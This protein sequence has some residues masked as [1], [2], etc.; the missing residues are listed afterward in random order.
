MAEA[1]DRVNHGATIDQNSPVFEIELDPL[2]VVNGDVRTCI[3]DTP[4]NQFLFPSGLLKEY[5]FFAG[6]LNGGW[7]QCLDRN[8]VEDP[9]TEESTSITTYRLTVDSSRAG[10]SC[11]VGLGR[12]A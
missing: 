7:N 3:S 1:M 6:G 9:L 8:A 5:F 2:Q 12:S 11:T 10:A 4:G